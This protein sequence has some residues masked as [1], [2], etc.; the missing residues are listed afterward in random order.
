MARNRRTRSRRSRSRNRDR[1]NGLILP[2]LVL[3]LVA[4]MAFVFSPREGQGQNEALQ[5]REIQGDSLMEGRHFTWMRL[6]SVKH[7][8]RSVDPD[9]AKCRMAMVDGRAVFEMGPGISKPDFRR[10]FMNQRPA[11]SWKELRNSPVEMLAGENPGFSAPLELKGEVMMVSLPYDVVAGIL[12]E[13][14][15]R[16]K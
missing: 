12:Y 8:V 5:M 14:G 10:I 9:S 11:A 1:G 15:Q 13:Y 4:V 7:L 16:R 2:G 6:D 3:G